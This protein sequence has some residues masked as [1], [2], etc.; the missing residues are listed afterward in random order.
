MGPMLGLCSAKPLSDIVTRGFRMGRT[1]ARSVGNCRFQPHLL[2]AGL[3]TEGAELVKQEDGAEVSPVKSHLPTAPRRPGLA[4]AGLWGRAAA[5]ME[6]AYRCMRQLHLL[7]ELGLGPEASSQARVSVWR[8]CQSAI[9]AKCAPGVTALS[10]FNTMLRTVQVH[11][12]GCME[13][14]T[15]FKSPSWSI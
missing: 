12:Q 1:E 13:I 6:P 8:S 15:V 14:H 11:R 9:S 7:S 5:H 2:P 10:Q 3:S 4:Q